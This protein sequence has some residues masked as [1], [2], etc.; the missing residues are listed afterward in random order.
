MSKPLTCDVQ[1]CPYVADYAIYPDRRRKIELAVYLCTPHHEEAAGDGR[2]IYAAANRL[3][4]KSL[5]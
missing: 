4:R 1:D 3:I 2:D 5:V